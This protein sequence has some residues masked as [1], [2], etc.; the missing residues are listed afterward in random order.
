MKHSQSVSQ[1]ADIDLVEVTR[2]EQSS[3]SVC[4]FALLETFRTSVSG[5]KGREVA[6]SDGYSPG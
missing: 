6:D 5:G 3:Q 4:Y 1:S 2:P